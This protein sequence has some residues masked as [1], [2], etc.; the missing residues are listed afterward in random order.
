M[1]YQRKNILYMHPVRCC[2]LLRHLKTMTSHVFLNSLM[3]WQHIVI[4]NSQLNY[5]SHLKLLDF[6]VRIHILILCNIL[7]EGS[8]LNQSCLTIMHGPTIQMNSL[9][10][11]F[12]G[13]LMDRHSAIELLHVILCT[14][15]F[16]I[17]LID[18]AW[19]KDAD[20]RLERAN[21]KGSGL[22]KETGIWVE[23]CV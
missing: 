10:L 19:S 9:I 14:N 7:R 5:V 16:D 21:D 11:L 8:K 12:N 18:L 13:C 17:F 20:Q 3:I 1:H 6:Y 23:F 4:L 2:H 15:I 22:R